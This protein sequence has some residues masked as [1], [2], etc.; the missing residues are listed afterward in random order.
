[1][2]T[3]TKVKSIKQYW[4]LISLIL[5]SILS[6]FAINWRIAGYMTVWMHYFM[7]IFLVI[8]S[9]LKRLKVVFIQCYAYRT[10]NF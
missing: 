5:V 2:N 3:K 1:M 10:M 4:P 9:A 8:L 6:A 7:G